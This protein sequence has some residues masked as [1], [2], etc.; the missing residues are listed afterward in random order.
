M[1]HIHHRDGDPRNNALD[2][3]DLRDS[4][5]EQVRE[6][7]DTGENTMVIYSTAHAT[8]RNLGLSKQEA[9]N[10]LTGIADARSQSD[11]I[12]LMARAIAEQ[13]QPAPCQGCGS[14]EQTETRD[15]ETGCAADTGCQSAP[16]VCAEH[17][18]ACNGRH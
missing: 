12:D 13:M 5:Y 15:G 4:I 17:R 10:R 14:T 3:L 8:L 11:A 16:D 1:Q 6:Q 7:L 2:H 18:A 9:R